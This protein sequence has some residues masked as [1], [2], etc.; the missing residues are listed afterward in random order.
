MFSL[1]EINIY[2]FFRFRNV[3][4]EKVYFFY[5][6]YFYFSIRFTNARGVDTRGRTEQN[7]PI[8][9]LRVRESVQ[10]Y[11]RPEDAQCDPYQTEGILL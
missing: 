10:V 9:L 8:S 1:K 3:F 2:I 7:P 5:K 11:G 4:L 6:I